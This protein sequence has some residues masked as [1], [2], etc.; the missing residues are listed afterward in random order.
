MNRSLCAVLGLL[1]LAS[2]CDASGT[3]LTDVPPETQFLQTPPD[4]SSSNTAVFRFSG[5]DNDSDVT[6]P[7]KLDAAAFGPCESPL[8]LTLA[9]GDHIVITGIA[10]A[11]IAGH[12]QRPMLEEDR[13]IAT[14]HR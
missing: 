8:T 2:A 11:P 7:C 5:T 14:A 6:N 13:R 12:Q 9:Q 4:P 10:R 3:D 1:S